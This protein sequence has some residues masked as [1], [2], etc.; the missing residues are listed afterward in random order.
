MRNTIRLILG[1]STK[2][3]LNGFSLP[4]NTN[5]D[6]IVNKFN[7]KNDAATAR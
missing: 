4:Y 3:R 1:L 5:L 6:A 2:E 7:S